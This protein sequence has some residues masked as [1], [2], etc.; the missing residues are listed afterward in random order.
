MTEQ[1]QAVTA[2]TVDG[3]RATERLL[4][5]SSKQAVCVQTET[6]SETVWVAALTVMRETI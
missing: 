1:R 6:E 4:C 3:R 5:L 2:A